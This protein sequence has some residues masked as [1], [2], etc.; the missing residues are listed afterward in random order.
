MNI[1]HYMLENVDGWTLIAMTGFKFKH[2]F[3]GIHSHLKN[4]LIKQTF[5]QQ[6]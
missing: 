2:L 5:F 3:Y 1:S 6:L 4:K